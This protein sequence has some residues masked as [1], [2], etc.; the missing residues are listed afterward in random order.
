MGKRLSATAF[1][2]DDIRAEFALPKDYP[3]VAVNEATRATDRYAR[4]RKDRTDIP[5]VTIDPPGSMDLDQAVHIAK[6][7]NGFTA[8]YAIADVGSVVEPGGALEQETWSRGQTM[9][10]PDGSV[11]L[12][13]K[14]LSEGTA[15]LLP[16]QI[17]PAA[18]WTI[19]LNAQGEHT[20]VNV[21]R[22]LVRSVARFDYTGVYADAQAGRLHAS[23]EHLPAVGDLR[24]ALARQRGAIELHLPEQEVESDGAGKWKLVAREHTPADDWNAEISLLTG[25]CA[26]KLMLDAK[27]GLLRTLPPADEGSVE[28]LR[29]C[30]KSLGVAWPDAMSPGEFLTGLDPNL[31]TTMALMSEA[32]SLLRGASYVPFDGE[33]PAQPLHAAIGLPYAHVTAPLRRLG[34]RYAT[35]VCLAICAGQPVPDWARTRLS[36][37]PPV[38]RESDQT[39]GKVDR[40]CVDKTEALVLSSRVGQTFPGAVVR[41]ANEKHPAD[42]FIADPPVIAPCDGNPTE[43][44]QLQVRLT[45]ADPARRAVRFSA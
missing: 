7:D 13:P 18:L 10:L 27:V 32:T 41:A 45:V 39:A 44:Q 43:G 34:D 22:A 38:L 33:L 29:K 25:T 3:A 14:V 28:A 30:A 24:M 26:A 19:E 1:S 4:Q 40:A 8:H 36:D 6:T 11:P 5:F 16:D 20:S 2:F 35:E 42:V 23:I 17:R 31:P 9:Y 15:S 12:H 37:L 21:H